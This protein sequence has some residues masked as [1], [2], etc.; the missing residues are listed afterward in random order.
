MHIKILAHIIAYNHHLY[1]NALTACCLISF[2]SHKSVIHNVYDQEMSPIVLFGRILSVRTSL[3]CA[4]S[5]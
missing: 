4:S 2:V 3:T 5:E 1:M